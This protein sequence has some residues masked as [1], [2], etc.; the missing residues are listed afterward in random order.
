MHTNTYDTSI[1]RKNKNKKTRGFPIHDTTFKF[2]PSRL[3]TCFNQEKKNNKH[4]RDSIKFLAPN[5]GTEGFRSGQLNKE[6]SQNPRLGGSSGRGWKRKL[7]LNATEEESSGCLFVQF[8]SLSL[9]MHRIRQFYAG[10]LIRFLSESYFNFF[11]T[12]LFYN[13]YS[14]LYVGGRGSKVQRERGTLSSFRIY[15]L[16]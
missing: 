3:E 10:F 5:A 2:C 15:E 6:K 13:F 7:Y 1:K 8:R 12:F 11:T 4:K 9:K 16:S 14:F